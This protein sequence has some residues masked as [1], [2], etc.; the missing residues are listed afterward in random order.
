MSEKNNY[1]PTINDLQSM[2]LAQLNQIIQQ[3]ERENDLRYG[4]IKKERADRKE[5]KERIDQKENSLRLTD[6]GKRMIVI[7]IMTLLGIISASI[8]D[9]VNQESLANK[10]TN[11]RIVSAQETEGGDIENFFELETLSPEIYERFIND[12]NLY[13]KLKENLPIYKEVALKENIDWKIIAALHYREAELNPN[14][15]IVSGEKLGT[16]N[17]DR[18]EIY[19]S[20]QESAQKSVEVFKENLKFAYRREY[21]QDDETLKRGF[22]AYNR[23]GAY[24]KNNLEPNDSPYVMNY[25]NE[26]FFNMHWPNVDKEIEPLSG[27]ADH[28]YGAFT[29]YK[30]LERAESEGRI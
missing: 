25:F 7:G 5:L 10:N 9:G 21:N 28:N 2:D 11:I 23:G 15:S 12:S 6:R 20:L 8:A 16:K 22:L 14:R 26:N 18:G 17:P 3:K 27:K 1:F 19:Y 30:I 24:V 4:R 29:V 13:K